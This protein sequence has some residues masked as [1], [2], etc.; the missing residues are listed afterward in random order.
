MSYVYAALTLERGAQAQRALA[1]QI[2]AR[3]AKGAR[4]ALFTP[5]IGFASNEAALLLQDMSLDDVAPVASPILARDGHALAPTIR[6]RTH[7]ALKPGGIYVHRWFTI[8]GGALDE[9]V[10]LSGQ[11]WPEFE[12]L[13]DAK[14]FG[15]F[16]AEET[17]EDR[18]EGARRLLL[19]TRY[20]DHGVWEKSRD[21]TTAAMQ[22]FFKR[23][24]LTRR[25]I[26]RS[27][28]LVE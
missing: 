4:V 19:I 16:A 8:D 24:Q 1:E 20:G 14:I 17:A 15:L 25:T 13:F 7:D 27:S 22:T 2:R 3:K 6:P 21:P 23:Q 28:L 12:S 18:A 10:A 5:Q 26:A 9:F 11:A